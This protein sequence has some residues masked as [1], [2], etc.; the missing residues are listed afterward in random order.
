TII[1]TGY[2]NYLIATNLKENPI[3]IKSVFTNK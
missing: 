2:K 1:T 3:A